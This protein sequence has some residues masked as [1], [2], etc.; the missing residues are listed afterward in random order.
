M[1]IFLI[2]SIIGSVITFFVLMLCIRS[3]RVDLIE[4]DYYKK[5]FNTVSKNI[6]TVIQKYK[7]KEICID[8]ALEQIENELK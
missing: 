1:L 4:S 5:H 8:E 2:G 6:K 3:K 7:S